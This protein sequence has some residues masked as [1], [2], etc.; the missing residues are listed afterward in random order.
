MTS[1][2]AID[3]LVSAGA[4]GVCAAGLCWSL[5][6]QLGC[7]VQVPLGC[8]GGHCGMSDSWWVYGLWFSRLYPR[9]RAA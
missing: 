8:V 6:V 9:T 3:G 1:R 4:I 2:T 5:L 7:V